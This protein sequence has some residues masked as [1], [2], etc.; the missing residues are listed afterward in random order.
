MHFKIEKWPASYE[1]QIPSLDSKE[2][3]S[4][5]GDPEGTQPG[6]HFDFRVLTFRTKLINLC[7]FKLMN[8]W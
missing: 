2:S 7:Y 6:P 3:D 4:P 1:K 8:L 5:L